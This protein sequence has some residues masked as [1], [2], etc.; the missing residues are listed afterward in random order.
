M[1]EAGKICWLTVRD[2]V[3]F[4]AFLDGGDLGDILLPNADKPEGLEVGDEVEVFLY[5]DSEDRLIATTK[6]PKIQVG[7]CAYLQVAEINNI[8]VFM[9]WGLPKQLLLPFNEQRVRMNEGEWYIVRAFVDRATGRIVASSRIDDFMDVVVPDY[10]AGQ[11]VDL[12]I[13]AKTDLGFRAIV[14]NEHW[15]VLYENEIFKPLKRGDRMKGF[16]KKMREDDKIDLC[17]TKPGYQKVTGLAAEIYEKLQESNG[18][19]AVTDKSSPEI[20]KRIF[21]VSKANFKKAIGALYK[22]RKIVIEAG[23]IRL[24][25][26]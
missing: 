5:F 1:I 25:D 2:I 16:I 11:E 10:K 4:G 26:E 17:L 14:N 23:G 12:M 18:Y 9:D 24:N 19:M 6:Q 15:G 21:G 13:D 22:Q 7:E 8:G 3:G 20:I